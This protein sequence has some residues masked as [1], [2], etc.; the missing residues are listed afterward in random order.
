[1]ENTA[2]LVVDVQNALV[3]EK[4]FALEEV[5]GNIKRLIE[6]CRKNKVEVIYVQ[7][8][9][10]ELVRNSEG[11]KI[12]EEISPNENE[13][14]VYKSFNSSFKNTELKEYLDSKGISQLIITGM[15]TEYCIDATCK[16]AFE[17]G[18]KLIMP[19]KT[20]TTFDN[21]NISAE[22]LYEYHNF[23]IFK[24]RFAVVE[25]IEDTIARF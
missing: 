7:H 3:S 20:N 12:Y 19:E 5:I 2:L 13:K 14:I 16:V 9:D 23:N 17:Y 22:T 24:N 21:G 25:N 10:E 11:W 15:Q 8:T 6:I 18:F 4:P 1:M